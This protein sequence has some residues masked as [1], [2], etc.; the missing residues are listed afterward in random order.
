MKLDCYVDAYF[1]VLW[2]HEDDKDSVCVKSRTGHFINIGGFPLYWVS[3]LQTETALSN[4]E[5]EYIDLSQDMR[6]LLNLRKLIQEFGTQ[7]NVGFES[8]TVIHCAVFEDKN[9][10][11]ILATSPQ[12]TPRTRH[13]AVKYHFFR[14]NIGEGKGVMIQRV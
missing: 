4:L 8:P 9:C 6:D 14:E 5:T 11:L 10:S 7:F 2:K 3:K 13:I 12:K 1:A